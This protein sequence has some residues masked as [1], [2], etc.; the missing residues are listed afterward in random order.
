[1]CVNRKTTTTTSPRRVVVVVAAVV[2][3][4]VG[5]ELR[6]NLGNSEKHQGKKETIK[7]DGTVNMKQAS[8]CR[9]DLGVWSSSR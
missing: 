1:M 4:V 6:I 7:G 9:G 2:V 5:V 8:D 3:T